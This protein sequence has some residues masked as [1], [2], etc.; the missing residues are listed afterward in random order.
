MSEQRSASN[1]DEDELGGSDGEPDT[2]RQS[3]SEHD[4]EQVLIVDQD[5]D[6]AFVRDQLRRGCGCSFE[7]YNQFSDDEV[8]RVRL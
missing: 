4:S 8:F 3:F 6:K 7:C 1:S 2:L 5:G